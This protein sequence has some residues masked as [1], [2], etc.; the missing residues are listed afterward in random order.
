M[1]Q[2]YKALVKVGLNCRPSLKI[3]LKNCPK[4]I[5]NSPKRQDF[6]KSGHTGIKGA[7]LTA[8]VAWE[9]V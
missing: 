1:S 7:T 5:K 6:A 3:P 4:D 2:L 9:K 8:V